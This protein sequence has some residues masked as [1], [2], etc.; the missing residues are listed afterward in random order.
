[1]SLKVGTHCCVP[2]VSAEVASL[3]RRNVTRRWEWW[4]SKHLAPKPGLV[5][6]RGWGWVQ[7]LEQGGISDPCLPQGLPTLLSPASVLSALQDQ[8]HSP[9]LCVMSWGCVTSQKVMPLGPHFT[10]QAQEGGRGQYPAV[11]KSPFTVSLRDEWLL[12]SAGGKYQQVRLGPES[13]WPPQVQTV[14]TSLSPRSP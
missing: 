14:L 13:A 1:M 2:A 8:H 7:G 10:G 11:F 9:A 12:G 4:D 6:Q 5:G 3:R